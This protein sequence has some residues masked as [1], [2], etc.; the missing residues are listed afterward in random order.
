MAVFYADAPLKPAEVILLLRYRAAF[1]G[2]RVLDLGVGSGRTTRY[3]APFARQYIGVDTSGEMLALCAQRFPSV[4]LE[5]ADIREMHALDGSTFDFVLASYMLFDALTHEERKNVLESV[6]R[7]L[8]PGG[9]LAFSAHNRAASSSRSPELRKSRNP[10]TQARYVWEHVVALRNHHRMR[11]LEGE[12]PS[13]ALRNDI[14][15][16]WNA[17]HYY[18]D[19]PA[20]E[21]QLKDAGYAM[22]AVIDESG[23][24]LPPGDTGR[25]SNELYYVCRP[26]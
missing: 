22:L 5:K 18:I 10:V 3:L 7:L 26:I 25:S 9:I 14:S 15:H 4:R 6:R 11:R 12:Y 19:R 24:V 13:Y 8:A 20:Q 16:Q 21:T 17:L 1:F 23:M 2:K